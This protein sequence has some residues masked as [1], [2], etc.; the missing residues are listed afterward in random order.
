ML[1]CV[2]RCVPVCTLSHTPRARY[3]DNPEKDAVLF[4]LSENACC[5][6]LQCVAVFCSMSHC[7]C[8][9]CRQPRE[10]CHFLANTLRECV[11]QCVA[12]CCIVLQCISL[13]VSPMSATLRKMPFSCT[14]PY[15]RP[16][17]IDPNFCCGV[18]QRVAVSP[19][20]FSCKLLSGRQHAPQFDMASCSARL[21]VAV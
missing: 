15:E 7:M 16:G 10:G 11:L 17:R 21:C 12:V 3:V 1:Q 6:V 4:I 14:L 19:R 18:L 9:L 5:R 2:L 13:H 8:A 20:A